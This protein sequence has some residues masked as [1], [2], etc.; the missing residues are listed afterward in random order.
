MKVMNYEEALNNVY[1][2]VK[3]HV[4][5]FSNNAYNVSILPGWI[6][7]VDG[8]LDT[9]QRELKENERFQIV[10]IKEKFGSLRIYFG[11]SGI[12]Q[13]RLRVFYSLVAI[14]ERLSEK[15]CILCGDT[16]KLVST[17][18]I[19]TKCDQHVGIR[20]PFDDYSVCA[21]AKHDDRMM[22]LLKLS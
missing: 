22:E 14:A 18:W 16:G 21:F 12:N 13:D 5:L 17:G 10:E 7:L 8:L 15:V 4:N 6:P 11:T 1:D 2:L 20:L 3:K 19:T 9:V